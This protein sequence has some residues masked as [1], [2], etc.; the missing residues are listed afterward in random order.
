MIR[1]IYGE[2]GF[3]KSHRVAEL[4]KKDIENGIHTFLIVPDQE[5]VS[6]ERKMLSFLPPSAQ[7][8][9]E[10]L[11]FS[12]LYNRVCREYGGL[13]YNYLTRPAKQL[14]MWR[15]LRELSPMLEHYG[16]IFDRDPSTTDRMLSAI[17]ELKANAISAR[18]LERAADRLESSSELSAKLRDLSLIYSA[19]SAFISEGYGDSAD[20]ISKLDT[21]LSE[22]DF[23]CDT[24]VYID[25]FTS[26][27]SAEHSV[28]EKIM[29]T[30][31]NVT[32]TIPLS[33]EG[34]KTIYTE[35]ISYTERKLIHSADQRGGYQ[36][37]TLTHNYRAK[38]PSL[39]Y[40]A[41][42][43]WNFANA[44]EYDGE[45]AESAILLERCATPYAE[46]EAASRWA[47]ELMRRGYRCRDILV[48][49]ADANK[50]KGIIEPAFERNGIPYFLSEKSELLGVI[51]AP[52]I[53]TA[54]EGLVS[55]TAQLLPLP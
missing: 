35:S 44:K 48:V 27:T 54:L 43:V 31:K 37:E 29:A 16:S 23:F 34:A 20:D 1:F 3:G 9:L 49:C 38:A 42:N 41:H 8:S 14:I 12:R 24:S 22:H 32:V 11:S 21:I 28:I 4:I 10:V 18:S 5:A 39:A 33:S 45:D 26:Y 51:I 50:Y 2:S 36:T 55:N 47:R 53:K 7:L 13:Q 30:A 19:Y 17:G 40:L 25:S 52:G 46:A 6:S 15:T